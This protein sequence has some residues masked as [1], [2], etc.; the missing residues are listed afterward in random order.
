MGTIKGL[1]VARNEGLR[2]VYAYLESEISVMSPIP[3][4]KNM[5]SLVNCVFTRRGF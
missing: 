5:V 4:G 1:K 3:D 2:R